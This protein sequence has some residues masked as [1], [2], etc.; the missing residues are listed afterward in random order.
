M[1]EETRRI[2]LKRRKQDSFLSASAGPSNY[3]LQQEENKSQH[4]TLRKVRFRPDLS[5]PQLDNQDLLPAF[6]NPSII[7]EQYN[8]FFASCDIPPNEIFSISRKLEYTDHCSYLAVALGYL[9][10]SVWPVVSIEQM[11]PL[12]NLLKNQNGDR[13]FVTCL[14]QIISDKNSSCSPRN[15]LRQIFSLEAGIIV[16]QMRRALDYRVSP[17]EKT[18]ALKS[19]FSIIN[20][21]FMQTYSNLL[22]IVILVYT[23]KQFIAF[24]PSKVTSNEFP[25]IHLMFE[26]PSNYRLF[27]PKEVSECIAL[28]GIS[29]ETYKSKEV[30]ASYLYKCT[31]Q[32]TFDLMESLKYYKTCQEQLRTGLYQSSAILNLHCGHFMK[33]TELIE[34]IE[35]SKS[36]IPHIYEDENIKCSICAMSHIESYLTNYDRVKVLGVKSYRELINM[37]RRLIDYAEKSGLQ[38]CT[39]CLAYKSHQYFGGIV[40]SV[41]FHCIQYMARAYQAYQFGSFLKEEIEKNSKRDKCLTTDC[42][43]LVFPFDPSLCP[44][45]CNICMDCKSKKKQCLEITCRSKYT[46]HHFKRIRQIYP[47]CKE[48]H[49]KLVQSNRSCLCRCNNHIESTPCDDCGK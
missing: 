49:I 12:V 3:S 32:N 4:G 45:N 5:D 25:V 47:T 17:A 48:C 7:A 13:N 34:L 18:R 35:A 19:T 11:A 27:V 6:H 1:V 30:S 2:K 9:A 38:K 44:K 26:D 21:A 37:D 42:L 10:T 20:Q 43:N 14:D 24:F 46:Q 31:E 8:E 16:N 39:E 29:N 33:H 36:P 23:K 15:L 40:P 41:C 22:K 28:E